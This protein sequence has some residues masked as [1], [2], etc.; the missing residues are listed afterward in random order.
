MLGTCWQGR[1]WVLPLGETVWLT[2]TGWYWGKGS[3][4][5]L[6]LVQPEHL[7]SFFSIEYCNFWTQGHCSLMKVQVCACL[8]ARVCVCQHYSEKE[9]RKTEG[10]DAPNEKVTRGH[11][12]NRAWAVVV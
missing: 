3:H 10:T 4:P 2:L 7:I 9:G 8:C 11:C 6:P 12:G 1:L 5:L